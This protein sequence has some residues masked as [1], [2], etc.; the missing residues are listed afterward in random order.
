MTAT[1]AGAVEDRQLI[2]PAELPQPGVPLNTDELIRKYPADPRGRILAANS[3]MRACDLATAEREI[4]TAIDLAQKHPMFANNMRQHTAMRRMLASLLAMSGQ[5]E[6]ALAEENL[7]VQGD[8]GNIE[9]LYMRAQAYVQVKQLDK[10]LA[11]AERIIG[12]DNT[13]FKAWQ[14]RGFTEYR[15][16]RFQ[17]AAT[18]FTLIITNTE[19]YPPIILGMRGQAHAANGKYDLALSDYQAALALAEKQRAAGYSD[20]IVEDE[21]R[22]KR[23]HAE[24]AQ[25]AEATAPHNAARIRAD[26]FDADQQSLLPTNSLKCQ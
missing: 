9:F 22:L 7:L 24:A 8:P 25:K 19:D 6:K 26:L 2:P 23:A 17:D 13:D 15:L 4:R 18:T 1:T 16:K 14:L 11:D 5:H 20:A 21:I 10:A 3:A 12:I